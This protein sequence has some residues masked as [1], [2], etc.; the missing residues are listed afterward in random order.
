M[1]SR[2]K[3]MRQEVLLK[4]LNPE[5]WQDGAG[6][7]CKVID[8]VNRVK[9]NKKVHN[10]AEKLVVTYTEARAKKDRADRERF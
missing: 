4:V 2:L 8:Y 6:I 3:K 9:E 10:L 7:R 1:A 5:G